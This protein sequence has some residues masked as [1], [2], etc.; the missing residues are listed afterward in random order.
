MTRLLEAFLECSQ[1]QRFSLILDDE[2]H[3]FSQHHK[4]VVPLLESANVN[5]IFLA[6]YPDP[7]L[8]EQFLAQIPLRLVG[9]LES[10]TFFLTSERLNIPVEILLECLTFPAP[11]Q[12]SYWL[13][14]R[15]AL[16]KAPAFELFVHDRGKVN[17]YQ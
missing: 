1:R 11:A 9:R 5:L 2:L 7:Y 12:E 3:F 10:N 17:F 16:N 8:P 6:Q 15:A 4:E 14:D 13:V